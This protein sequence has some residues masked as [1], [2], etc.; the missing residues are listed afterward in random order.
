LPNEGGSELEGGF[1]QAAHSVELVAAA[2][3]V[4]ERSTQVVDSRGNRDVVGDLE[5]VEEFPGVATTLEVVAL[6]L[7]TLHIDL[8]DEGGLADGHTEGVAFEEDVVPLKSHI[9][10]LGGGA[11][12][13]LR[14]AVGDV[15]EAPT[16]GDGRNPAGLFRSPPSTQAVGIGLTIRRG[17]VATAS[18]VSSVTGIVELQR[19]SAYQKRWCRQRRYAPSFGRVRDLSSGAGKQHHQ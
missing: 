18:Q 11:V 9:P 8:G 15:R 7:A 6:V 17:T 19:H 10:G 14:V 4:H 5:L 12:D 1:D 3:G 13:V 16:G 2:L